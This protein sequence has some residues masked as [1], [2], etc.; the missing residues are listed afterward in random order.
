MLL[1]RNNSFK[2][3][4]LLENSIIAENNKHYYNLFLYGFLS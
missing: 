4:D 3:N 1:Y 2:M